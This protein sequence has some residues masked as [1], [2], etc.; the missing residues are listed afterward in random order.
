MSKN[1]E[2]EE[3][4]EKINIFALGNTTVGKTSYII[5]YTENTF[6]QVYLTT[7]GLD[8]KTKTIILPNNKEYIL[9]FYDTAG[10]ER[11]RSIA[12]NS[13]KNADGILLFYDIT[14]KSSFESISSWMKSIYD[15]KEKNFPI[16]LLGN[17]CDLKE[18]RA[19]TKEEGK[20]KANQYGCSFY[21]ISNKDRINIEEPS[22]ELL[23]K[24]IEY[25]KGNNNSNK[26]NINLKLPKNEETGCG[27]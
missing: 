12:F 7:T 17:K 2:K 14:D 5:K 4:Q 10:E 8:Y 13:I 19:V 3:K 27:C 1:E 15:A 24:I 26:D 23:D 20:Q 11:F 9:F 21:E 25:Q 18:E 22:K 16:I 6:Q